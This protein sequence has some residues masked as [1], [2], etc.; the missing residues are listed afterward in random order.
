MLNYVMYQYK[1]IPRWLSL[2][3]LIGA[4]LVLLY[5]LVGILGLGM[6]L[7]SPYTLLAIPIAVQ[8]MVFAVWLIIKGFNPSAI[9][10]SPTKQ[11]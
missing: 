9:Q 2:W 11:T 3:G 10:S 7:T 8:E 6:G 5:G 1:L 4:A